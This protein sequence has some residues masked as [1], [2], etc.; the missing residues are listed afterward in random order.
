MGFFK[1]LKGDHSATIGSSE[2]NDSAPPPGPPPSHYQLRNEAPHSSDPSH[3]APPPGPPP[4]REEFA[5]GAGPLSSF[6]KPSDDPPPYHDWTVI[7]DNSLL[8]P[9]PS[10]GY[11][12]SPTGSASS[13]DAVRA[14]IWCQR[15]PL[16]KPY[17]P[18]QQQHA[19]VRNGD[20]RITRPSEYNGDLLMLGTGMWR[21]ST[22]LG[23]KD[24]CLLTS[25]PLYFA[26]ADSPLVTRVSKTIYFE[27]KIRS[28]GLGRRDDDSL[29]ALGY[30]GLPYP[31][32]RLPGWQRGSL[33]VHGDDGRKY[34]NDSWGGK[35]FTSSFRERETVGLGMTFSIPDAP[36]EYG[37]ARASGTTL[38]VEVFLTRNGQR[39]DGWNLHEQLDAVTD[40]GIEGLDGQYDLFG[41]LGICGGVEFDILFRSKDWLWQ[42]T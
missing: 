36:P 1:S 15:N 20:I 2:D 33:G 38:K 8:P 41:A 16:M 40:L 14:R 24:T 25:L 26:C 10:L 18:S 3:Y 7:P 11:D 28:L 5:P 9:P 27:V 4:G 19:S 34:V 22:K 32:W 35:D 37:A 17:Q 6:S 39:V 21:G 23:T 13:S 29:I 12:S 42:P 30:T 31:T